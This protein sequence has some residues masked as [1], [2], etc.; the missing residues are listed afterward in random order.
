MI[1]QNYTLMEFIL[2][3]LNFQFNNVC[4]YM[5]ILNYLISIPGILLHFSCKW[6]TLMQ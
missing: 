6:H 3:Y 4:I 5:I 1:S 2:V